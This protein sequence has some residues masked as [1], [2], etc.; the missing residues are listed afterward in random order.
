MTIINTKE[1]SGCI[2]IKMCSM[3][4][5]EKRMKKLSSILMV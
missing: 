4:A 3:L 1:G 5:K 2:Q